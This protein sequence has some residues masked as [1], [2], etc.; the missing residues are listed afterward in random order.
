MLLNSGHRSQ[1]VLA[2]RPRPSNHRSHLRRKQSLRLTYTE[3]KA[4]PNPS[5]SLTRSSEIKLSISMLAFSKRVWLD[6]LFVGRSLSLKADRY[7]GRLGKQLRTAS[8][9]ASISS[10]PRPPCKAD[11]RH[12][13]H[14]HTARASE[15]SSLRSQRLW[16]A[17]IHISNAEA[18]SR[19]ITIRVSPGLL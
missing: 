15:C 6:E 3:E 2:C 9:H 11:T 18:S 4:V 17:L 10:W 7:F 5:R 19:P 12:C 16:R 13:A 8:S 14:L 1:C